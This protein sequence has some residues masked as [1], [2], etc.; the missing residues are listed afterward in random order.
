MVPDLLWFA[1]QAVL[2]IFGQLIILL[3]DDLGS[4]LYFA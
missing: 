2:T 4:G 3:L 1:F